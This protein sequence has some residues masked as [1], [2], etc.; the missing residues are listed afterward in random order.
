[1]NARIASQNEP[2]ETRLK[3]LFGANVRHARKLRGWPQ[4]ELSDKSG[5][6]LD[7]IGR[8]ERGTVGASFQTISNLART[9]DVPDHILFESSFQYAA[10]GPRDR[11]LSD[12]NISL[13]KMSEDELFRAKKLLNALIS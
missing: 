3:K 10:R 5:I 13:A 1:M 12:I 8:I 2:E 4:Q 11:L 9:L 7:T 6:S